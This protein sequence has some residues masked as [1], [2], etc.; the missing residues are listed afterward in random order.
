MVADGWWPM[1]G[2]QWMVAN[3]WWPMDGSRWMVAE[4]WW[5]MDGGCKDVKSCGD[6][7]AEDSK[8]E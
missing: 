8:I 7:L 3:G 6:T 4:G 2:G 1:D 5:L